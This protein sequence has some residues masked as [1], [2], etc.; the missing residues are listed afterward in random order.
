MP[1][2]V[3][4]GKPGFLWDGSF[5]AHHS[6]AL[7]NRELTL[8]LLD[9]NRFEFGIR[10]YG[11]VELD[12]A[13]DQRWNPLATRLVA[14]PSNPVATIR[15][16]WP[17]DFSR[18]ASGRLVLI[19]PWEF[20]SLPKSWVEGIAASVDEVWVPSHFVREEY[21]ASGVAGSKVVVVPNGVNTHRFHPGIAPAEVPTSKSYKFLF[22]GG[23][24]ARKGIDVLLD[25]YVRAFTAADDVSLIIKDFGANSFYAG[26]D[27]A[28][29]ITA[30]RALPN[31]PEIVHL[32]EDMP[33]DSVASLY[34][35]CDA[36]VHPYRGEGYG[37][38]IAEAMA[39]G[40]P[41]IV[42][43][44]GA[45]LDFAN[46]S[47][48]FLIPARKT[49]LDQTHIG[50]LVLVDRA[51]WAEP[52]RDAL[53]HAMRRLYENPEEGRTIGLVAAA[54]I[55]AKHT[56]A[57]AAAIA[58]ERLDRLASPGSQYAMPAT[59][60]PPT[61]F[62][63]AKQGAIGLARAGNWLQAIEQIEL[64]GG[65][66]S[67][68]WELRNVLGVALFRSGNTERAV[69]VLEAGIAQ[70][71]EP[72]D[73]HHNLAFV[74]LEFGNARAAAMHAIAAAECSPDN[75]DIA[76]TLE[77]TRHAVI[78]EA[79]KL[80][81]RLSARG[82]RGAK[83]DS[84]FR[85]LMDLTNRAESL[86]QARQAA[87]AVISEP[88]VDADISPAI[89]PLP[90][91]S[92]VMIV[93]DE[94]KFLKGC[95]ESVAGIADEIVV[96][97]TGSTDG[98]QEIA[99][100]FGAKVVH[101]AWTDDFS[102]ARNVSL[103]HAT[104]DWAL[105]I[106]ADERLAEGN[107]DLLK[108]LIVEAQ[109]EVGGYMVNIR[110]IM[111]E[112]DEPEVCWHRACRLFRLD[113]AIRFTGRVH[114]QNMRALQEA[115]YDCALSQLTLDHYGYTADVMD[116]RNKHERFIRMLTREVEENQ[117]PT[118][119]TFH[120]FNLGNAY[121]TRGDLAAAAK[122]F[123]LAGPTADPAQE[124][125]AIMFVE[126]A[127]ALYATGRAAE[128][129]R[130]CEQ[131]AGLG[132]DHPGLDFARGHACLHLMRY[133]EAEERFRSAIEK[134][135]DAQFV[136]TG[137]SGAYTY[138]AWYGL[139]LAVTGQDRYQD[140]VEYCRNSLECSATFRDARYLLAKSLRSIGRD[141]EARVELEAILERD[142]DFI[143]ASA[144]LGVLLADAGDHEAALSWLR[145]AAEADSG[146]PALLA[147][148]GEC[149]LALGL[150]DEAADTLVRARR[151]SPRS[152]E[153]CVNL[154]RAHTGMGRHSD[155]IDA[156]ADAMFLDPSYA[157][158]YFNAGDV[159]YRLGHY[160]NA[161]EALQAGLRLD[162]GNA[163]GF[164]VL[165][166]CYFNTRDFAAAKLAYEAAVVRKPDYTEA[167]HN[168]AAAEEVLAASKAA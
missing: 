89:R 59:H 60:E 75:A 5:F 86:L 160:P 57:H 117:Y 39:C 22:V 1:L 122:W 72:R 8:A 47:N 153:L 127:T 95:L 9:A 84:E 107:A 110:N 71:P 34:A 67:A 61:A 146:S 137:D 62:E 80:R 108:Y 7:V 97:D 2:H 159:L 93:K 82:I 35:A 73:F 88:V 126:W 109:P 55:A 63:T 103:D 74:L 131:A 15:H 50:D 112:G 53:S 6:L 130:V 64:L 30:V 135:R 83:H 134:G 32:T 19:Q 111:T 132:I 116:E 87:P 69:E 3:S 44:F 41:A 115:G 29:L 10:H 65:A 142:P 102:A 158:A 18:P 129:I 26:Q 51:W 147:R 36:L 161:A 123:A 149:C 105:W 94:S 76:R 144:D 136:Q 140:A 78:A 114:E 113:T 145:R 152:P 48:S 163:S 81:K 58:A 79:R 85:E 46:S 43:G 138:K 68:D 91:L 106:D 96:V 49:V 40:K 162:P 56:W 21:L 101:H 17:A 100:G 33:E 166:N 13:S 156:F 24:I 155:A 154:G 66:A 37:L 23:T 52:D 12:P 27:A 141:D 150:F 77:R 124:Y 157:N 31:A 4:T 167:K 99:A 70:C 20:G 148:L 120:L 28:A 139:A 168:L 11:E 104:G 54:D 98:T 165:G 16:R 42:T 38:P 121:F 14:H 128:S 90:R 125:T 92:V 164:L 25:A 119:R 45:A 143:A 133:T 118:E 151:L